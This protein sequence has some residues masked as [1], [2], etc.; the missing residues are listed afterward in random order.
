MSK[1]GAQLTKS[2]GEDVITFNPDVKKI[3]VISL[4]DLSMSKEKIHD[5]RTAIYQTEESSQELKDVK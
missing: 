4:D 2:L 1:G 3:G 5:L